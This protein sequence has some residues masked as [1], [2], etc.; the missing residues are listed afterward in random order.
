MTEPKMFDAYYTEDEVHNGLLE[1]ENTKIASL[2][3]ESQRRCRELEKVRDNDI[4]SI[5]TLESNLKDAYKE[6]EN[7]KASML[8][9]EVAKEIQIYAQSEHNWNELIEE[10]KALRAFA[11]ISKEKK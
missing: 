6:L 7:L 11:N 3:H 5:T 4:V 1:E 10:N 8:S 2:L 9:W